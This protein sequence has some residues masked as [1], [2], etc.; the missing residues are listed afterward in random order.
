M[1]AV[2][3]SPNSTAA[4]T[5]SQPRRRSPRTCI[6]PAN[7]VTQAGLSS[8]ATDD[9]AVYMPPTSRNVT[10]PLLQQVKIAVTIGGT[11]ATVTYAGWVAG[12]VAGLYQINATVPAKA[13]AGNRFR[14]RWVRESTQ[15]AARPA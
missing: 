11:A 10:A 9:G 2:W 12:S 4:D 14:S 5:D 13:A 1:S 15:S 7:Y 3:G 8:P 6:S